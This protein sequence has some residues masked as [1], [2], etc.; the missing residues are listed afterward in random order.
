MTQTYSPVT[1]RADHSLLQYGF[2]EEFEE[3]LLAA[4]DS[5]TGFEMEDD[6]WY[7]RFHV[8]LVAY[9]CPQREHNHI[10]PCHWALHIPPALDCVL[11]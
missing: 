4:V 3:P 10:L 5:A 6:A 7:G 9:D 1:A 2:V 11:C 8:L